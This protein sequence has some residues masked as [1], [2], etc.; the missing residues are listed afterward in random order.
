MWG[1]EVNCDVVVLL[2]DNLGNEEYLLGLDQ[3]IWRT[4]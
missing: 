3:Y 4:A 1:P 2:R